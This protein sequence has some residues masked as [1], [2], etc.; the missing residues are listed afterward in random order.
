MSLGRPNPFSFGG[1]RNAQFDPAHPGLV[2]FMRHP[3]LVALALWGH[4]LAVSG[5][6][7]CIKATLPYPCPLAHWN[8]IHQPP[9]PARSRFPPIVGKPIDRCPFIR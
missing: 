5:P 1:S 4:A 7:P 3:L 9:A 8:V 2:R 6:A